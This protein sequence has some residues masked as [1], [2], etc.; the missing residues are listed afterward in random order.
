MLAFPP[1]PKFCPQGKSGQPE[2]EA[3]V[4]PMQP[5]DHVLTQLEVEQMPRCWAGQLLKGGREEKEP[6]VEGEGGL[7]LPPSSST[8]DQLGQPRRGGKVEP[9][10]T[11][12]DHQ[13]KPVPIRAKAEVRLCSLSKLLHTRRSRLKSHFQL[14]P[15]E[16]NEKDSCAST[17]P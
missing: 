13:A 15:S 14:V 8:A 1:L 2:V 5:V 9:F 4:S 12:M 6:V 11:G 3:D 10:T 16:K 7:T 17:A